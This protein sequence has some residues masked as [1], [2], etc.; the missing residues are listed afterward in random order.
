VSGGTLD[1]VSDHAPVGV[2]PVHAFVRGIDDGVRA[3]VANQ[4]D[5]LNLLGDE[6][7]QLPRSRTASTWPWT[8]E[9]FAATTAATS[10]FGSWQLARASIVGR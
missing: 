3:V 9:S 2:E 5:R 7:L 8:C 6:A 1:V 4:A 10:T